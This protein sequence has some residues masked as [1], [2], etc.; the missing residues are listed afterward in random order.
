MPAHRP[1][2]EPPQPRPYMGALLAAASVLAAVVGVWLAAT[3]LKPNPAAPDISGTYLEDGRPIADF[4]LVDQHGEPFTPNRLDQHWTVLTFG[5]TRSEEATPDT[6]GLLH[7]AREQLTRV[8]LDD[9]LEIALV[10]IDPEHDRPEQ[11]AAYLT[12]YP[13]AFHGLTG[14]P[15]AIRKLAASV[16]VRYREQEPGRFSLQ[17]RGALLV[18]NP[19]GELVALLMPPHHPELIAQDLHTLM[20]HHRDSL[21]DYLLQR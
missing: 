17:P 9:E 18:M 7:S 5:Y 19:E 6:L 4:Q 13:K 10:T 20:Q 8:E 2:T 14:E 1:D 3:A 16:G 11:L 21:L 15:E 12:D